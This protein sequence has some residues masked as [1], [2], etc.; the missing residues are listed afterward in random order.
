MKVN[1]AVTPADEQAEKVIL[2]VRLAISRGKHQDLSYAA[3]ARRCGVS[4]AQLYQIHAGNKS[5]SLKAAVAILSAVGAC[6]V[7]QVSGKA[8]SFENG[9]EMDAWESK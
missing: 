8:F 2:S 1:D 9:P 4:K 5:P 3:M 7:V 6:L